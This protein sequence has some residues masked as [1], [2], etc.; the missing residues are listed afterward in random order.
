MQ[1][2]AKHDWS[3]YQVAHATGAAY[4][5]LYNNSNGEQCENCFSVGIFEGL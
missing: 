4:Q 3:S 5:A 1:D 2:C